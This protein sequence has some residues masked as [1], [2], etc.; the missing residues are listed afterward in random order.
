MTKMTETRGV[1][2]REPWHF[3]ARA[4]GVLSCSDTRRFEHDAGSVAGLQDRYA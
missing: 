2:T 1:G 3:R 4:D